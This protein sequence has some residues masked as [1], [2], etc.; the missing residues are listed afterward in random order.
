MHHTFAVGANE[1]SG[2]TESMSCSPQIVNLKI[3]DKGL[4][5]ITHQQSLED[6]MLDYLL[7]FDLDDGKMHSMLHELW[8]WWDQ[9]STCIMIYNIKL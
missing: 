5:Y 1:L 7:F 4:M 6:S 9:I 2:L 3:P 8:D